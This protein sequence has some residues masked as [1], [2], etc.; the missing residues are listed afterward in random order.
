[1]KIFAYN[2]DSQL[3]VIFDWLVIYGDI[4]LY[5]RC[6]VIQSICSFDERKEDVGVDVITGPMGAS[7]F[8]GSIWFDFDEVKSGFVWQ[9]QHYL[10]DLFRIFDICF[11]YLSFCR[12]VQSNILAAVVF[13]QRHFITFNMTWLLCDKMCIDAC[14]SELTTFFFHYICIL[15]C[16]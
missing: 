15:F 6:A 7:H 11:I 9:S 8:N 2:F 1:M 4:E 13:G 14:P 16:W 10:F 12:F 5:W 3:N